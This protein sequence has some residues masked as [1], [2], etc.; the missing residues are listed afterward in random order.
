MSN[1]IDTIFA[2]A[3]ALESQI[4][5]VHYISVPMHVTILNTDLETPAPD[6]TDPNARPDET[7]SILDVKTGLSYYPQ[8]FITG[9]GPKGRIYLFQVPASFSGIVIGFEDVSG[10]GIGGINPKPTYVKIAITQTNDP[11]YANVLIGSS[12]SLAHFSARAKRSVAP[13][14]L[15]PPIQNLPQD[16]PGYLHT[17]SVAVTLDFG[18]AKLM[19]REP[20]IPSHFG[21]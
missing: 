1:S 3:A 15:S 21:G 11:A 9:S 16:Q 18:D 5:L 17:D 4:N 12:D 2:Q 8:H 7:D 13:V 10:R 6:T 14:Q 20:S 19:F